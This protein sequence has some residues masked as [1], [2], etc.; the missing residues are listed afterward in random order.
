MHNRFSRVLSR[1]AAIVASVCL[2]AP[3]FVACRADA[4]RTYS[5]TYIDETF[6][7][8]LTVTVGAANAS[9]AETHCRAVKDIVSDLHRRFDAYNTYPGLANLATV[10]AAEPGTAVEVSP[11][12][13]ALLTLGN[14][15]YAA[16]DGAVDICLGAVTRLWKDAIA[17]STIPDPQAVA[18][19]LAV[20]RIPGGFVMDATQSTV[21]LTRA[22]VQLD[23]GAIAKGYVLDKVRLY[24]E[25][26]GIESLLCNLGGEIL[27]IGS[28]P[29]GNPW[30]IAVANPDGGLLETLSVRDA[31]VATG[32]D[33]E[34]GFVVDGRRYHHIIDPATG[35]P[36]EEY[37]AATVVLPTSAAARSDAYSTALMLLSA[38]AG[39]S[40]MA[41]TPGAAYL[42]VEA[43]GTVNTGGDWSRYAS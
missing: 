24:A 32:G 6:D 8:V 42:R 26:A 39:D 10:N 36:S 29:D 20:S 21:T 19:A 27:A 4:R 25:E 9:D 16:T 40:L 37:R 14:E 15:V 22:G 7:T 31:V 5:A 34:R 33:Y 2:C 18:E 28:A 35:Y 43:D 30:E 17:T 3:L 1:A 12:I 13:I 23:V 11:D 38:D 41:D